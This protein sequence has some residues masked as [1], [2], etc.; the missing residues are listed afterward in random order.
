MR[1][2][3]FGLKEAGDGD[4]QEDEIRMISMTWTPKPS[5]S[6]FETQLEKKLRREAEGCVVKIQQPL[7]TPVIS[8]QDIS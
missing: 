1:S 4:T 7:R 2:L 5:Q 8:L 6:G 3:C